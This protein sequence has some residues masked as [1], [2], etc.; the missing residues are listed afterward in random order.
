MTSNYERIALRYEGGDAER[1]Q[2]DLSQLGQSMQGF[3]RI[4]A[5]CANFIETGK[6]NKQYDSLAV[7]VTAV[8]PGEHHCYEVWVQ[9][10]S[11]LSSDNLWSGA[12]G[13]ILTALVTYVLSLRGKEEMKHLK[14]ALDKALSNSAQTTDKLIATIE[15][16]ADA[17]RPAPRQAVT[18]IG[19]SCSRIDLYEG[20]RKAV[21]ADEETK[22]N[23][24]KPLKTQFLPTRTYV[25]L[26]SELDNWTGACK[27]VLDEE[28]FEGGRIT[29]EITDPIR[30]VPNNP[31][32]MALASREPISFSAKAELGEDGDIVKLFI[33][34][35]TSS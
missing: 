20:D 29:A 28:D 19:K 17:L 15:K 33:S 1:H 13:S 22:K 24:S 21:T 34:D 5:V 7:K 35:L 9:I 30:M 31:Y 2:I 27:V 18:P 8:E 4:L 6:Y 11:L 25:G 32:A 3:A 23:V 26:V 16:M 14:D 10:K 12:A